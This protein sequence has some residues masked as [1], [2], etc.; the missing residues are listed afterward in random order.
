MVIA[1]VMKVAWTGRLTWVVK[2]EKWIMR[3]M[4]A[5]GLRRKGDFRMQNSKKG[6]EP[7]RKKGGGGEER[8]S[9]GR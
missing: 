3:L 9:S 7:I 6:E 2:N 8:G 5:G 1:E 4:D